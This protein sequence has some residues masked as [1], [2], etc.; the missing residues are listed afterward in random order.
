MVRCEELFTLEELKRTG[1]RLK[2]NTAPGI[3]GVPNE[4]LKEVIAVYP[5]ILLEAF[6]SDLQKKRFFNEW[7]RQRIVLLRKGEKSLGDVS[8][9]RSICVLD[10]MGK[11]PEEMILQRL[12][13]HMVD[14]SSHS[15]NQFGY[16]KGRSTVKA[17]QTVETI[18]RKL[19]S[20]SYW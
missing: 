7:K 5:E 2:V 18:S 13:S 19:I 10:S 9:Y 11:L 16:R 15:E 3:D 14:E 1:G 4:I 20:D 8:S 6:N 12:Q 17:I